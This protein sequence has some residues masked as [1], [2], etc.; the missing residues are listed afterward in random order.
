MIIKFSKFWF[1][2]IFFIKIVF[3]KLQKALHRPQRE[4]QLLLRSFSGQVNIE[5]TRGQEMSNF[6]KIA[7]LR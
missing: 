4:L 2:D 7:F 5:V 3:G 1:Y 6:K